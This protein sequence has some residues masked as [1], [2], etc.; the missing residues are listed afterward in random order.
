MPAI[1]LEDVSH[2][3]RSGCDTLV[4]A[5]A[6]LGDGW[7]GLV[8]ANGCGKST[9]LGILAGQIEPTRGRVALEPHGDVILCAQEV[10]VH[11]PGIERFAASHQ[12]LARRWMGRLGLEPRRLEQWE[13][14]SAG[15]RKRWQIGAALAAGPAVLL[16]DEPTNHLD[17]EGRDLLVEALLRH[18]GVG[19]VVSHDRSLLDTLTSR[20]LRLRAGQLESWSGAYSEA[21]DG[22]NA[23]AAEQV[24]SREQVRREQRKLERRLVDQRR[25]AN[26]RNAARKRRV[27]RAHPHDHDVRSTSAKGRHEHGAANASRRQQVTGAASDRK[28]SELESLSVDKA[29]GRSLFFDYE[30][31]RRTR[32]LSH[33]GP[34]VAGTRRLAEHISVE[35]ERGEKV[36]LTGPNGAGK[37]TLIR[38]LIDGHGLPADKLLYLP[39]ETHIG[40]SLGLLERVHEMDAPTRGRVCSL[41]AALGADPERLLASERPSPGEARKLAL[42]IGLGTSAW[43]LVLDEP[44]N[45][46]DLPAVERLEEALSAFPG[47]LLLVSHDPTFADRTTTKIWHLPGLSA[48]T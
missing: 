20:T 10:E 25:T 35:L 33:E 38:A 16:L 36:H 40:T 13:R 26:S 46:L 6:H 19:L 42:A 17:Q 31:A 34:L 27:R 45:H 14:L 8:G 12:G 9:L 1:H 29:L 3:Y 4:D 39:Q 47:A 44:T 41:A 23:V 21:R 11:S 30:P 37:T 22:W 32:M 2:S 28:R 15:E 43:C 7:T 5:T 18:R 48:H 24:S